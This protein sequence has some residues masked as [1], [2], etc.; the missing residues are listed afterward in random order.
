MDRKPFCEKELKEL[1]PTWQDGPLQSFVG[2]GLGFS[3]V[4]SG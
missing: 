2:P 3:R 4:K 1:E